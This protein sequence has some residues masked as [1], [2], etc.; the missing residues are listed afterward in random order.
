MVDDRHLQQSR[1]RHVRHF[2]RFVEG[3]IKCVRFVV[4]AKWRLRRSLAGVARRKNAHFHVGVARG[5]TAEVQ[6]RKRATRYDGHGEAAHVKSTCCAIVFLGTW[7]VSCIAADDL[8]L[9]LCVCVRGQWLVDRTV[10]VGLLSGK[11]KSREEQK[12]EDV[13][14]RYAVR[15]YSNC[16][17]P[18]QHPGWAFLRCRYLHMKSKLILLQH[19]TVAVDSCALLVVLFTPH[20]SAASRRNDG[21]RRQLHHL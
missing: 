7:T 20:L 21:A 5:R 8:G 17:V 18:L 13:G 16:G 1:Q 4:R 15:G 10:R 2:E 12:R 19:Q 6:S 9:C 3:R 11:K 14:V